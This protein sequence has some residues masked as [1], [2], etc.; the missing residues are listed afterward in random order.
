MGVGEKMR[1]QTTRATNSTVSSRRSIHSGYS[2]ISAPNILDVTFPKKTRRKEPQLENVSSSAHDSVG[3]SHSFIKNNRHIKSDSSKLPC[4]EYICEVHRLTKDSTAIMSCTPEEAEKRFLNFGSNNNARTQHSPECM[5]RSPVHS[6][7]RRDHAKHSKKNRTHT[8]LKDKKVTCRAVSKRSATQLSPEHHKLKAKVF[9]VDT[10][11][12]NTD[13]KPSTS[14]SSQG[15]MSGAAGEDDF[16]P[17]VSERWRTEVNFP[18]LFT[19]QQLNHSRLPRWM[20]NVLH[21]VSNMSRYLIRSHVV[22][23]LYS[24]VTDIHDASRLGNQ[25]HLVIDGSSQNTG[26]SISGGSLHRP[27]DVAQCVNSPGN[28]TTP[29]QLKSELLKPIPPSVLSFRAHAPEALSCVTRSHPRATVS[30]TQEATRSKGSMQ[31]F[32]SAPFNWISSEQ[33]ASRT[34]DQTSSNL[35]APQEAHLQY[36]TIDYV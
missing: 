25:T 23:S 26:E 10:T 8:I 30:S 4:G 22:S 34:H 6:R 28:L 21:S 20:K 24:S 27:S 2:V 16:C 13:P 1:R 17:P 3:L 18:G 31:S 11:R 32:R 7:S 15:T 29:S 14:K 9:I 12:N 33:S 35:S 19:S 36:E 5:C